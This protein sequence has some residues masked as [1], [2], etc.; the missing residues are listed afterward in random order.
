MTAFIDDICLENKTLYRD[1]I[2]I[3]S[4]ELIK[5]VFFV[6]SLWIIEFYKYGT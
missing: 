6:F 3:R 5:C 4:T 2:S 1:K